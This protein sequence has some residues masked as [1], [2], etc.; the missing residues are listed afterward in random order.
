MIIKSTVAFIGTSSDIAFTVFLSL[1]M[2][3]VPGGRYAAQ[4]E[5]LRSI[6]KSR[7]ERYITLQDLKTVGLSIH[8]VFLMH[9]LDDYYE[10]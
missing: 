10:C 8:Y 9:L 1:L 6:Y 3:C 7:E 4:V 5:K 2:H